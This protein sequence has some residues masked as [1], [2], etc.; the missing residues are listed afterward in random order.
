M[1]GQH[2]LII[3]FHG[4]T[5]HASNSRPEQAE[6]LH[7]PESRQIIQ[8]VADDTSTLRATLDERVLWTGPPTIASHDD[9][10]IDEKVFE[11]DNEIVNAES[12]RRAMNYA[13]LKSEMVGNRAE[14]EEKPDTLSQAGTEESS[15]RISPMESPAIVQGQRPLPYDMSVASEP[16]YGEQDRVV[17]PNSSVS[18]K[19]SFRRSILSY[20]QKS[21][22]ADKKSFW[23][24]VS[25][26]RS[27]R[28]PAVPE[29]NTTQTSIVSRVSTPGSRRGRRGFESSYHTS[30]DFG[31]EDGLS[32][33]PIV[34]AAQAG[35]VVE[36]ETL[37]DQ[38][39]DI[40][41]RHV[42]SGRSALSV[43]SHCGNEEVVQLLLRYGA[44]VNECDASLLSALHLAS[45]RG[46][47][48]V[49]GSLLKEHADV[50]VKGPNDRTPLRIAC[51]KGEIEVA[52][53]LLRKQAKVNA[54]PLRLRRWAQ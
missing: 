25:G 30:I 21:S 13:R 34:R 44:T 16:L 52:E 10:T 18:D 9:S 29:R 19:P 6:L 15:G 32:A 11:W 45:M 36:V 41:A 33:P 28:T 54:N 3:S 17:V 22:E 42:Q 4:L 8:R 38:R 37:L 14:K 47:V 51:E 26:K 46:H 27:T 53:L 40:N 49:V 1:V 31:S 43:A 5:I 35:S 12:Y 24:T 23:S 20:R 50:D 39:A 48:E 2:S 7:R